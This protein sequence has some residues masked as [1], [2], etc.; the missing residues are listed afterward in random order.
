M[1]LPLSTLQLYPL[2]S[3]QMF[4]Q[5]YSNF[6]KQPSRHT[7]VC[8]ALITG[9]LCRHQA[10]Q[11]AQCEGLAPT[12]CGAASSKE[13]GISAHGWNG[14]KSPPICW[15]SRGRPRLAQVVGGC[16]SQSRCC[17]EGIRMMCVSQ[18]EH[19]TICVRRSVPCKLP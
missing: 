10:G 2:M 5:R 4:A 17:Q 8:W 3:H 7:R 6:V 14:G 11:S 1:A 9:S 12:D 13:G 18:P 15:T 16:R 19:D